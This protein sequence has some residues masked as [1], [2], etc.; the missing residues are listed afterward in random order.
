MYSLSRS[1]PILI[2]P[3]L[4][5]RFTKP[6]HNKS[7]RLWKTRL[8]V[9]KPAKL[10]QGMRIGVIAPAGSV[11]ESALAAGAGAIRNEGYDVEFAPN[12][13]RRKGYLAGDERQ[14][15]ADLLCF[16]KRTDIDAI[17]CA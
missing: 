12:V 1:S 3:R 10:V 9:N 4:S 5:T 15:A 14:R 6:R 11:E 2:P 17:F 13:L 7:Y 16:F 8:T